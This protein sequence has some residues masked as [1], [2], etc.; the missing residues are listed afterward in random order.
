MIRSPNQPSNEAVLTC[1]LPLGLPAGGNRERRAVLRE[2]G[3]ELQLRLLD[4]DFTQPRERVLSQALSICVEQIGSVREPAAELMEELTLNDRHALVHSLLLARGGAEISAAAVCTSCS[5]K[6]VLALDLRA[7]ELPRIP[8]SGAIVLTRPGR[9]GPVRR[10]LRIPV[11]KELAQARDE[12]TILGLCLGCTPREAKRWMR[13]AENALSR[14]DPLSHLEILGQCI[15]CHAKVRAEL[16]PA[17]HW[18][19]ILRAGSA[20]L[21]QDIHRLALRYHW[22]E[23][24]ILGLPEVRRQAYLDLSWGEQAEAPNTRA[25]GM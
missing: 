6:L 22:T 12:A 21:V 5:R 11:A 9:K 19:S 7:I 25:R 23:R 18:L 15:D 13:P 20:N 4:L 10:E 8:D 24:E 17:A 3:E 1:E 14:L 2:S 16:D